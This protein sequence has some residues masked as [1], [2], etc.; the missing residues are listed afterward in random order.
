MDIKNILNVI[1]TNKA[2]STSIVITRCSEVP[3]VNFNKI[4]D[5]LKEL[6]GKKPDFAVLPDPTGTILTLLIPNS[7]DVLYLRAAACSDVSGVVLYRSMNVTS[8]FTY[9]AKSLTN[10]HNFTYE[11][12]R[13]DYRDLAHN[14][15]SIFQ[16]NTFYNASRYIENR[17]GVPVSNLAACEV[18]TFGAFIESMI[19]DG[20]IPGKQLTPGEKLQAKTNKR[21]TPIAGKQLIS[22]EKL[23]AKNDKRPTPIAEEVLRTAQKN[24]TPRK[25]RTKENITVPVIPKGNLSDVS[26]IEKYLNS[27]E[28]A[29]LFTKGLGNCTFKNIVNPNDFK[30]FLNS[31]ASRDNIRE[32]QSAFLQ[33]L[34]GPDLKGSL[35][36]RLGF[37]N[38][39]MGGLS[40]NNY[41]KR[42]GF[43][44]VNQQFDLN[45]LFGPVPK[46]SML[47]DLDLGESFTFKNITYKKRFLENAT[48]S[49]SV[50]NINLNFEFA[51][52]L[53]FP[54]VKPESETVYFARELYKKAQNSTGTIPALFITL[55]SLFV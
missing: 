50:T 15:Q 16:L 34:L 4:A 11:G 2:L 37:F 6:A 41:A 8:A 47:S 33:T 43:S 21:P 54:K 13:S 1:E 38:V 26:Y 18:K 55:N 19:S 7:T 30:E 23:Q 53:R 29:E 5:I 52:L 49:V 48:Y 40:F 12:Q 28:L 3:T 10:V 24:A 42:K 9:L 46:S 31:V 17:L 14:F 39:I 32:C 44:W 20:F 51:D 27:P 25:K 45:H 35:V 22:G 36:S